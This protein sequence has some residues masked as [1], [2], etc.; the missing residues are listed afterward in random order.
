M[1]QLVSL[2]SFGALR[3]REYAASVRT[4][5]SGFARRRQAADPFEVVIDNAVD[6]SKRMCSLLGGHLTDHKV[7]RIGEAQRV[8]SR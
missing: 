4:S 7:D 5:L 6:D 2:P 8:R 1:I 3:G